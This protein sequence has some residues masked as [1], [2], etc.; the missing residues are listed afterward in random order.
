MVREFW[1]TL[2]GPVVPATWPGGRAGRR[3]SLAFRDP[4]IAFLSKSRSMLGEPWIRNVPF[5]K[6]SQTDCTSVSACAGKTCSLVWLRSAKRTGRLATV[7]RNTRNRLTE[8]ET[9]MK[10][11]T[12]MNLETA[13]N[14]SP[15]AGPLVAKTSNGLN[16]S[17]QTYGDVGSDE[18]LFVHGFG[19]SR[20][21]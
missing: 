10:A 5:T 8:Q 21:S 15:A 1:D 20:L 12:Y 14:N 9:L 13:Q 4:K 19:P 17:V 3:A 11:V 7:R 6:Q 18:I 2:R 16:L